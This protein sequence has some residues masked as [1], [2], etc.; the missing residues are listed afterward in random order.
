MM[1]LHSSM[2]EL[3]IHS[4]MV[5]QYICALQCFSLNM[6]RTNA[7]TMKFPLVMM[8]LF[9]FLTF[10]CLA[11]TCGN[12][13]DEQAYE[14]GLLVQNLVKKKN[15][16]DLFNLI[17]GELDNG[18]RRSFALSKSFDEI[19]DPQWRQEILN[20]EPS[21]SPAGWRGYFLGNGLLWYTYFGEE[22]DTQNL[23]IYAIN[24]AKQEMFSTL[25]GWKVDDHFLHPICFKS[26]WFDDEFNIF[27][28]HF[29]ITDSKDFLRNPGKYLGREVDEYA[30]IPTDWCED[31]DC[32]KVSLGTSI[33]KCLGN[34]AN[35]EFDQ[36]LATT[37]EET[38]YYPSYSIGY[39]IIKNVAQKTC[40]LLAPNIKSPCL[41]SYF[42]SSWEDFGGSMGRLYSYGIHGLFDL[43]KVGKQIIPLRYFDS[44]NEG[45][46]FLMNE[47]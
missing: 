32:P 12:Q 20:D 47:Q 6:T 36:E 45:L 44:R 24:G 42:V 40:V 29:R 2:K 37:I 35:L 18:P 19:F 27:T 28:K 10:S 43:P 38:K 31:N 5:N 11:E 4:R 46:N 13:E 26:N 9:L 1:R 17:D 23:K 22:I 30:P 3:G 7:R 25:I 34:V 15:T 14:F 21:C 16:I 41:G 39:S 33:E 8:N